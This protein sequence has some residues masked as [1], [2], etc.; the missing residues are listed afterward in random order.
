MFNVVPATDNA[1]EPIV[2][3]PVKLAVST[4]SV[5]SPET[6]ETLTVADPD[7]E[8]AGITTDT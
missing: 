1:C 4:P 8:P 5:L 7:K 6:A 3:D 2:P